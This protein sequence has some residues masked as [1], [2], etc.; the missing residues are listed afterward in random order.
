[1]EELLLQEAAEAVR[2]QKMH[3]KLQKYFEHGWEIHW[4]AL[5]LVEVGLEVE[6][7]PEA[8]ALARG[9][10]SLPLAPLTSFDLAKVAIVE[11]AVG[12]V[13]KVCLLRSS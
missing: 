11:L 5:P 6:T 1:M 9:Q 4:R 8:Q 7:A 2:E 13:V 10:P 3:S 12:L